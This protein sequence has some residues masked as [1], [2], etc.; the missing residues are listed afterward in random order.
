MER[1]RALR[2]G[3]AIRKWLGVCGKI[4]SSAFSALLLFQKEKPSGNVCLFVHHEFSFVP[5]ATKTTPVEILFG[6]TIS[7]W[8]PCFCEVFC[9]CGSWR[10]YVGAQ[11]LLVH[12]QITDWFI[13][14]SQTVPGTKVDKKIC[15]L[16]Y[17]PCVF[18]KK[19]YIYW[20]PCYCIRFW[21][22]VSCLSAKW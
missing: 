22:V 4:A 1:T 7:P 17:D 18:F 11:Y 19:K 15:N 20:L 21:K 2:N 8:G 13:S 9:S 6:A 14:W 3:T 5:S 12:S 10:I 16:K